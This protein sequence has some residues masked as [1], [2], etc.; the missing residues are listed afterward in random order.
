MPPESS[1]NCVSCARSIGFPS[2]LGRL[3]EFGSGG[4]VLEGGSC[5][6]GPCLKPP[7]FDERVCEALQPL[8][9]C[10]SQSQHSPGLGFPADEPAPIL[11]VDSARAISCVPGTKTGAL[12]RGPSQD[13]ASEEETHIVG[14]AQ[15]Q[16]TEIEYRFPIG[17]R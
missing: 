6:T 3:G 8:S 2:P 12:C 5:C 7:E 9:R 10:G 17:R 11:P 1:A 16:W 14:P 13:S 15:W 4:A